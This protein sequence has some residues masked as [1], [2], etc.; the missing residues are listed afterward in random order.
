[1]EV[2]PEDLCEGRAGGGL[3]VD[4]QDCW[5]MVGCVG[6]ESRRHSVTCISIPTAGQG[7]HVNTRVCA[8]R[9]ERV[10]REA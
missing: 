9:P 10:P 1:M 4:N 7:N 6:D 2:L 8:Y 3:I 5:S